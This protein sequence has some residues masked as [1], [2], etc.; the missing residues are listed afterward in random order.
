LAACRQRTSRGLLWI[1]ASW[2]IVRETA[3]L[4]TVFSMHPRSRETTRTM[5]HRMGLLHRQFHRSLPAFPGSLAHWRTAPGHCAIRMFREESARRRPT[6]QDRHAPR[7]HPQRV[8]QACKHHG[9]GSL[10]P[11]LA[12]LVVAH[13][14]ALLHNCKQNITCRGEFTRYLFAFDSIL[15]RDRKR[16]TSD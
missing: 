11:A 6:P 8:F 3:R 2:A 7:P 12:R 14:V 13:P 9:A 1:L 5:R 4:R 10:K 15:R 16:M